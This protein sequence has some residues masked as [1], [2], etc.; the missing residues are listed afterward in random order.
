M[1]IAVADASPVRAA[2]RIR[3]PVLVIHG[4][5]DRETPAEHSKR[6]YPALAGPKTLR[7]VEGGGHNGPLTMVWAEVEKWIEATVCGEH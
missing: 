3:V 2:S 5:D 7:I 6:V 1:L 4:A